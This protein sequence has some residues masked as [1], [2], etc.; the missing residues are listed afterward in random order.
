[1]KSG[2]DDIRDSHVVP[3]PYNGKAL[4]SPKF[5]LEGHVRE[6][7][8]APVPAYRTKNELGPGNVLWSCT[9]WELAANQYN[10]IASNGFGGGSGG[11][12]M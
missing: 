12:W 7:G 4:F 2:A 8:N 11:V 3:Y 9:R 1:M 6:F 10:I 5:G